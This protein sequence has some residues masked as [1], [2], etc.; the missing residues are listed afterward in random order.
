MQSFRGTAA[1]V[2]AVTFISVHFAAFLK[3]VLTW[4]AISIAL[5][6]GYCLLAQPAGPDA[7]L[8]AQMAATEDGRQT[9]LLDLLPSLLGSLVIGVGWIRLV[10]LGEEP[11]NPV[12]LS[13]E[14]GQYFV[15]SIKIGFLAII[16]ALPGGLIGLVVAA[17]LRTPAGG[18]VAIGLG[19]IVAVI[20]LVFAY[21][22]LSPL[23][24]A[25]AVDRTMVAGDA[26]SLT[27]GHTIGLMWGLFLS[28][29][30]LI[31]IVM[32]FTLAGQ[33][34]VSAGFVDTGRIA[35]AVSL[36]V[37]SYGVIALISGFLANA[38][39]AI[40]PGDPGDQ[41]AKQFE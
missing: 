14:M 11:R 17:A 6:I 18:A 3:L 4:A 13:G 31:V 38:Y 7:S 34:F 21:S 35:T 40:V 36:N 12:R 30:L 41:I 32:I 20:G 29:V 39:R 27:K 24:P 15:E 5:Q 37:T 33:L 28:Y 1:V 9:R 23:L 16:A 26:F 8:G 22:R 2:Q 10:L 25:A 19:G